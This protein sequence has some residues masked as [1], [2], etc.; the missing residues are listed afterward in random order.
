MF[1]VANNEL[2]NLTF[3]IVV[4]FQE[5]IIDTSSKVISDVRNIV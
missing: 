4:L 2:E 3:Y 1:R 5:V